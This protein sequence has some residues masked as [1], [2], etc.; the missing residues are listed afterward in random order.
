MDG[1]ETCRAAAFGA[2]FALQVDH[3]MDGGHGPPTDEQLAFYAEEA[4]T[5]AND[6]AERYAARNKGTRTATGGVGSEKK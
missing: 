6:A 4:D 3:R 1:V 5:V 2:Y